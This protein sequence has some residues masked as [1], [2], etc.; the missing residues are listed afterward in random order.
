MWKKIIAGILIL[1]V[2]VV[3]GFKIVSGKNSVQKQ[4]T[5]L[6]EKLSSYHLE[7][8]L[9]MR[10]GDEIRN[11]NVKV[12]YLLQ[13]GKDYYRVSL[14][15]TSVNQEQLILR[16]ADGVYV[17]TPSLN[18]V[19]EF[20]GDWPNNSP[21]PYIYQSLLDVFKGEYEVQK[22]DDG[23]LVSSYPN[24]VNSNQWKK[25]EI[26]FT[27]DFIPVWVNIY[28]DK[29]ELKVKFV[30]T[31]YEKNPTFS[32]KYFI[33]EDN[34][35]TAK[36]NSTGVTAT[37]DDLPLYPVG[38]NMAAELKDQTVTKIN[39]NTVHI[40]AYDGTQSFTVVQKILDL[41]DR[42]MHVSTIKGQLVDLDSGFGFYHNNSLTYCYNGVEYRIYSEVLS[43][44]ELIEVA[45]GMEVVT[46]K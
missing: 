23:Y 18:Q 29:G 30:V 21:K 13:D 2:I 28:G 32:E 15:D 6:Q 19:Y 7:G 10:N 1:A 33:L 17:L 9:E 41:D 16:N 20:Q 36:D 22:L 34:Y 11:Y 31:N 5:D 26:K 35:A 3:A 39:G 14:F 44:A 42:E 38:A 45:N 25:Q 12:S 8:N 27:K 40:L 37:I 24:F 46:T 4:A 43:A